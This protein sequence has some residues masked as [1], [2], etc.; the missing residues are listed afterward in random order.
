MRLRMI[1]KSELNATNKITTIG[2]LAFPVLRYNFGI[3]YW[4]MEEIKQ[5]DRK[6]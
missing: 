2:A 1:Q 6:N 4:R 3:I 5:I